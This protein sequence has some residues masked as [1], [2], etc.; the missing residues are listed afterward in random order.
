[1]IRTGARVGVSECFLLTLT[2]LLLVAGPHRAAAQPLSEPTSA[3]VAAAPAAP[4]PSPPAR[5]WAAGISEAEQARALELYV[6]GNGEFAESRFAQALAKYRDA[7][8]HWDHPAIRFNMTVCL[9]H[10]GQPIDA[11]EHLEK[12]LAY[13]PVALG[14]E[15]HAQAI[16]Y[17]KLLDAQLSLLTISCAEPGA[18]VTLDGKPL[19]IGPGT[20]TRY[21]L[22]GAHQVAATKAGLQA[23]LQMLT[24]SPAV[25]ATIELRPELARATP[26]QLV[27][28]W[29]TWKPWTVLGSG[30]A[31]V[32][33]G[34]IAYLAADRTF[35]D[36]DRG[37]EAY[38]PMGCSAAMLAEHG[39]LA[40]TKDRA[41]FEQVAAFSLFSVGGVVAVAGVIGLFWNQPRVR[42]RPRPAPVAVLP[43]DGGAAVSMSWS[44]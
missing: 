12:S 4:S 32:A 31:L 21:L 2:L 39:G 28:R 30:G 38:C 9:I 17:R 33:A 14:A 22:P 41:E 43:V 25:P 10:L 24:L 7:I 8:S 16:T 44:F 42:V 1:M 20:A 19:F 18:Q 36:Y 37:V 29:A 35:E 40:R 23:D 15:A 5:P 11:R 27:R 34:A 26:P 6:E 3:P 13:G